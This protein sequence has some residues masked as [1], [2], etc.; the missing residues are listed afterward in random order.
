VLRSDAWD[1][2]PASLQRLLAG[3]YNRG[4]G[5]MIFLSG[6]EHISNVVRIAIRR[7]GDDKIVVAHSIHS[8][9]LYAPYPF[10]NGTED[11]FAGTET[12]CFL[13]GGTRYFCRVRT[14]YPAVGD[15]FAIVTV[16]RERTGWLV[17]VGFDRADGNDGGRGNTCRFRVR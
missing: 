5:G 3:V 11:D 4:V 2:Y 12:F 9:A 17:T 16:A 10:A 13:H 6:D 8:S 7:A 1:G 15:G 14:W